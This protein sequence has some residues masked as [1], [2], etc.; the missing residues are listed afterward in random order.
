MNETFIMLLDTA[1]PPGLPDKG[2]GWRLLPAGADPLAA[3]ADMALVDADCG[4]SEQALDRLALPL[5]IHLTGTPAP[6]LL[7]R[8]IGWLLPDDGPGA[9]DLL[10]AARSGRQGYGVA[11]SSV[12]AQHIATL[13]I[14][15]RRIAEALE[16]LAKHADADPSEPVSPVLVRRLIRLRR[17]RER[18]FPAEIFADPA[19][20]M[21]LDL[22][23]AR[24]EGLDVPVSSLCIAAAVPTT[25]ALRW[26]RTLTE[27]GLLERRT[28]ADDARRSFVTLSDT[29]HAAMQAWIRRFATVFTLR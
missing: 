2:A 9:L 18:H 15:A 27:A 7:D 23:A 4:L 11:E 3:A 25:T 26:I 13:S 21:L 14:E 19:W 10:V 16:Q 1:V 12:T 22:T 20:D 5:I 29:A 28:D 6:Q 17:D 8:A 24:M